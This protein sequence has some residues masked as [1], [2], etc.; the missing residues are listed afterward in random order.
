MRGFWDADGGCCYLCLP[1]GSR[2]S[3][4]R[5][6]GR[7]AELFETGGM[8]AD[9]RMGMM[10]SSLGALRA[11]VRVICLVMAKS[12]TPAWGACVVGKRKFLVELG[13]LAFVR[14]RTRA[15]F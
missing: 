3:C 5:R 7:G 6:V 15:R 8:G 9:W 10:G 11:G 1:I 12:Y 2:P 14:L 13:I 4:L